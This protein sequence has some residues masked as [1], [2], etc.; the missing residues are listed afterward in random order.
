MHGLAVVVAQQ[1]NRQ[2]DPDDSSLL[3]DIALFHAIVVDLSGKDSADELQVFFQ[4]IRM[5]DVLERA[6]HQ[7]F[8][9]V[10]DDAAQPVVEKQPGTVEAHMGDAHRG[11]LEG[12]PEAHLAPDQLLLRIPDFG[13]VP[14]HRR[15]E[16]LIAHGHVADAQLDGEGRAVLAHS[17]QLTPLADDVGPTRA[18][19]VFDVFGVFLAVRRRL[20][21]GEGLPMASPAE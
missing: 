11:L 21:D 16:A 1:G 4:V 3:A 19:V 10:A 9:R 6:P 13:H 17:G 5:G 2:V 8:A 14:Q 12:G 15:E 20:K 18:Q 7:L